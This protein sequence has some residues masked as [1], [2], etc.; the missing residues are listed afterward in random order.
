MR[1]ISLLAI[2][3]AS[4]ALAQ[5]GPNTLPSGGQVAAGAAAIST[6]SPV[7]MNIDQSSQNAVINWQ[8][9]SIGSAARVN[10][11]QPSFNAVTLNR[12]VGANPSQIF[13]QITAIG[14]VFLSN[15]NGV[16]F[17]PGAS[18]DV[19]GLVAT[20]LSITDQDFLAGRYVFSRSGTVG[21]VVNQG[22]IVA[23]GGYAAL[24]GP[25]VRND[26]LITA[27]LGNVTL[28]AGDRVT[29]DMVGDRLIN[30]SVDQAALN[31]SVVNT[32]TIEAAGGK[33]LLT[34]RSA[35]ALL[36]TVISHS[37][38]IRANHM[39]VVGGEIVLSG[40]PNGLVDVSGVLE[41]P[42][43]TVTGGDGGTGPIVPPG[44]VI[45]P[46]GT[47]SIA[48]LPGPFGSIGSFLDSIGIS[49][50]SIVVS[51][52]TVANMASIGATS[53]GLSPL[54]GGTISL[55]GGTIGSGT[56]LLPSIV[57]TGVSLPADVLL[58]PRS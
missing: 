47:I 34:A 52:I 32:G 14:N 31:A 58:A 48:G 10:I 4:P 36:D 46:P 55:S 42:T 3:L 29:V 6:P 56:S 20:T 17:A 51:A 7:L 27:Q 22:T 1:K 35:N 25:Q 8:S 49:T 57:G 39:A 24:A 40:G 44:P 54:P 21:S 5:V 9:F 16:L 13:G 12:V 37:G 2:A 33:V 30:V 28:A 50:G 45:M 43:I 26:G 18:V 53:V 41:A 19:G 38:A 15:P 11:N 23:V